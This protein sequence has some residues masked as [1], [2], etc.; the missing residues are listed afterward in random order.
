MLPKIWQH[1]MQQSSLLNMY[2][3]WHPNPWWRNGAEQIWS[4]AR[5]LIVRLQR[6]KAVF[7]QGMCMFTLPL[8]VLSVLDRVLFTLKRLGYQVHMN[9]YWVL[10]SHLFFNFF[11]FLGSHAGTLFSPKQ[12]WKPNQAVHKSVARALPKPL[13]LGFIVYEFDCAHVPHLNFV[14]CY[15][16]GAIVEQENMR[17]FALRML[18]IYSGGDHSPATLCKCLHYRVIHLEVQQCD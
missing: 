10:N 5:N 3:R 16:L 17:I 11:D 1:Q 14:Y 18:G 15:W 12:K 7:S 8:D 6:D 2:S 13:I 9:L 4:V